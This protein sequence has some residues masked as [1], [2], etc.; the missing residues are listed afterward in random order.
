MPEI[1]VKSINLFIHITS[2]SNR[3]IINRWA[4]KFSNVETHGVRL[5][6]RT[7]IFVDA[8]RA[9]LQLEIDMKP[10]KLTALLSTAG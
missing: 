9:S 7:K 6:M 1:G 2:V 8:R 10:E 5:K 3:P 4:V